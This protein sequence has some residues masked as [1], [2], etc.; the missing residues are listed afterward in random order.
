MIKSFKLEKNNT[1][2]FAYLYAGEHTISL[3]YLNN[4][5]VKDLRVTYNHYDDPLSHTFY[6]YNPETNKY[7]HIPELDNAY[8]VTVN[9]SEKTIIK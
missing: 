7:K 9:N 6:L 3:E 2:K 8:D 1:D 4:D 5:G